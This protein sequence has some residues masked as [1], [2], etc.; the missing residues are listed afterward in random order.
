MCGIV[1]VVDLAGATLEPA[2]L[3]SMT[4]AIHYRGPDDEGYVLINQGTSRFQAYSGSASPESV[5]TALPSILS[6]SDFSANIGLAHRRFSIIDLS[7][8][9]HQPLFSHDG[10]CCVVFNGEIY[11]YIELREELKKLG[12][13]FRAEARNPYIDFRRCDRQRT[14]WKAISFILWYEFF[15]DDNKALFRKIEEMIT[16]IERP[17]SRANDPEFQKIS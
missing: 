12:V 8:D 2:L 6:A 16:V 5:R 3:K 10:S 13:K 15:I 1:V 11:N 7:P 4:D 14:D 9:G 17:V